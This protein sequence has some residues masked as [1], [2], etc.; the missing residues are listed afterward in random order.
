MQNRPHTNGV[1]GCVCEKVALTMGYFVPLTYY[2]A[3]QKWVGNSFAVQ[4]LSFAA[5]QQSD[6]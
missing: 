1:G 4:S 6:L 2:S 3:S 5:V